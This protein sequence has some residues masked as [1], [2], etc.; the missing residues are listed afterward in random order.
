MDFRLNSHNFSLARIS[1]QPCYHSKWQTTIT[2]QHSRPQDKPLAPTLAT[3]QT[4]RNSRME[5]L[6]LLVITPP[7]PLCSTL[8][9]KINLRLLHG[10]TKP[11]TKGKRKMSTIPSMRTRARK[12]RRNTRMTNKHH[13]SPPLPPTPAT[14]SPSLK[15]HQ[16]LN[17]FPYLFLPLYRSLQL[18][19]V[20][21]RGAQLLPR[22]RP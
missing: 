11:K 12:K 14:T 7:P 4:A 21:A 20:I 3:T 19:E 22:V 18:K 13:P 15:H 5:V 9:P 6:P 16:T 10:R 8:Q 1:T 17:Q 2:K